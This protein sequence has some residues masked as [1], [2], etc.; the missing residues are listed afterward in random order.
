MSTFNETIN[1]IKN[2]LPSNKF[3]LKDFLVNY[4]HSP[5]FRVLLNHRLGKYLSKRHFFLFRHMSAYYRTRLLV[6]RGCDISYNAI[7][8]KNVLMPHPMGIVIGDKVEIHDNVVIFQQVTFGSHGKK[9]EKK[10]YPIVKN[11]A[12][13]YAGAKIIG[14]ITIGENAIVGANSVV[15]VDVPPNSIAVGIPCRIINRHE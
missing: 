3:S 4:F 7:V 8:G 6:K 2:D 14:G 11:G 15:N 13:I 12:K 9:A 10:N 1:A 5:R